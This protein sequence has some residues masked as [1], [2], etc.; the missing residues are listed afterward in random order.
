MGLLDFFLNLLS[1]GTRLTCPGCGTE[2]ARKNPDGSISCKNP[3]CRYFNVS[4]GQ[5]PAEA[6]TPR[7][8]GTTLRTDGNFRP[9]QPVTIRYRNFAGQDRTFTAERDSIVRKKNHVVARVAPTGG[10]ITLSCDRIQNLSEVEAGLPQ[11]VAPGQTWPTR[12]ERQVLGY[13]KKRGTTSPL[14]QQVRAKY[15]NW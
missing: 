10:K 3:T 7:Q 15:P 13:H 12:R 4:P 5:S 9:A 14:Y 6:R 2:G 11:R 8:T 1:G